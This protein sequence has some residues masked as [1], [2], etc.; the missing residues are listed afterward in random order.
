MVP[1]SRWPPSTIYW[2]GGTAPPCCCPAS[3]NMSH[4]NEKGSA[5][6]SLSW[7]SSIH[8]IES[9][10]PKR[11]IDSPRIPYKPSELTNRIDAIRGSAVAARELG[12]PP[13]A[14]K[15]RGS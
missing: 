9:F 5:K 6:Q 4:H 1:A 3:V 11:R 8:L 13:S 14:K 12:T 10:L 2:I 7:L 15:G